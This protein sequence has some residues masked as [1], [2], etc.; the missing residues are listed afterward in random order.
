MAATA[1]Y[2]DA[3]EHGPGGFLEWIHTHENDDQGSA[4]RP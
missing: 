3:T 2:D 4:A 1:C